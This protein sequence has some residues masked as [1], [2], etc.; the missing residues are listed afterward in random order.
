MAFPHDLLDWLQETAPAT[1]IR[2]SEVLFPT[3]ETVHVLALVLVV[4]TIAHVDLR[5][6]SLGSRRRAVTALARE[7]LP[8]TWAAFGAAVV[9]GGLLFS[10]NAVKYYDNVPFRVKIALLALA[11]V[12]MAIFHALTW[13]GV[14]RWDL[15][16]PPLAAQL[17]GGLSLLLWVGIVAMGRWIGFTMK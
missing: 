7:V 12:N 15:G 5:L 3:I 1:A 13:R 11:G 17:A 14:R 10:S 16:R 2:E 4:G 6:L 9:S 8:W